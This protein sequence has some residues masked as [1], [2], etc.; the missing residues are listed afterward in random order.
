MC[1]SNGECRIAYKRHR[2][3]SKK[4]DNEYQLHYSPLK[5]NSWLDL[6]SDSD[7]RVHVLHVARDPGSGL[8]GPRVAHVRSHREAHAHALG[9]IRQ[10]LRPRF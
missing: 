10:R 7:D 4:E 3:R 9:R 6:T 1:P 5:P 8:A 2:T